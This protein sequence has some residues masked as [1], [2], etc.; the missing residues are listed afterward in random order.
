MQR[1]LIEPAL[2]DLREQE[3]AEIEAELRGPQGREWLV[4][5]LPSR[6]HDNGLCVVFSNGVGE[7]DG[8]VRTGNA[9]I[10]G[11]DDCLARPS[12]RC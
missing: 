7:D 1:V 2:W 11:P 4:R 8:K 10:L 6:A 9:M 3:P 12:D 5:W